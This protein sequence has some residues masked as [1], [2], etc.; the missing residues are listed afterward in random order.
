MLYRNSSE[1]PSRDSDRPPYF[2]ARHGHAV[3]AKDR[4]SRILR[5]RVC[6]TRAGCSPGSS[7]TLLAPGPGL[8]PLG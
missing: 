5:W 7:P 8:R 3:P 4:G 6:L 1:A 2:R